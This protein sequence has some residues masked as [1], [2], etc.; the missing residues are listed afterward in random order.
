MDTNCAYRIVN[1]QNLINKFNTK[2]NYKT[3]NDADDRCRSRRNG[4]TGC[5]NCHKTCKRA[6][7]RHGNIRLFVTKPGDK[8]NS[9]CGNCRRKVGIY[10]DFAGTY[11]SIAFHTDSRSTVKTK[12]AEPED[13]NTKCADGQVV[14]GNGFGFSAF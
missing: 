10:K 12:P 9:Y 6:V 7:Q 11:N 2:Y 1:F 13:E 14:T 4:I 8:H 5:C 3:G